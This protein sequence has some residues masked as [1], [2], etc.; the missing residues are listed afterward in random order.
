M[1]NPLSLWACPQKGG[2]P[3]YPVE[4]HRWREWLCVPSDDPRK[5]AEVLK[6]SDGQYASWRHGLKWGRNMQAFTLDERYSACFVSP[7]VSGWVFI[8]IGG[9]MVRAD[10]AWQVLEVLS[11]EFGEAQFFCRYIGVPERGRPVFLGW[12]RALSGTVVRSFRYAVGR[13][14]QQMGAPT[15]VEVRMFNE[16]TLGWKEGWDGRWV[17][18]DEAL[19]VSLFEEAIAGE[20][21]EN[22][23]YIVAED[24]SL[25][26]LEI[27]DESQGRPRHGIAGIVDNAC[28][29]IGPP[30]RASGS[31]PV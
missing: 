28:F 23:P 13:M 12:D 30:N 21:A 8:F 31:E 24:W 4:P 19:P 16:T 9:D 14:F 27:T 5:V 1:P 20:D 15:P 18:G 29:E 6:L 26:P 3:D 7:S 17:G 11:E 2:E 10:R 22:L 25:S